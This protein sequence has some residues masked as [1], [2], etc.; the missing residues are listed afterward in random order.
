MATSFHVHDGAGLITDEPGRYENTWRSTNV[1][2]QTA[3]ITPRRTQRFAVNTSEQCSRRAAGFDDGSV[4]SDLDSLVAVIG[5]SIL[6]GN[7]A[8]IAIKCLQ[9]VI[10]C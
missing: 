3:D 6:S 10:S 4:I 7:G 2:M 9:G 8:K 5:V 1:D